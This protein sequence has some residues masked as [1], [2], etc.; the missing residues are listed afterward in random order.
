MHPLT[1]MLL[2]WPLAH[3]VPL[4]RRDRALVTLA[5]IVP[6]LDGLALIPELLTRHGPH[7][8]L[9]WSAYHAYGRSGRGW[10]QTEQEQYE[11]RLAEH[12]T[13]STAISHGYASFTVCADYDLR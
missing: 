8:L 6:D 9:W 2:G 11:C 5:G 13:R 7:P 1:H 4:T 3:V 12:E 10:H